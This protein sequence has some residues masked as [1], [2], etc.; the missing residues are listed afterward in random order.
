MRILNTL[1]YMAL[2]NVRFYPKA[3]PWASYGIHWACNPS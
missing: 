3:L 2:Y 1:P